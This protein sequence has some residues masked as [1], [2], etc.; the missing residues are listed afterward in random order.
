MVEQI[1]VAIPDLSGNEG[2]YLLDAFRSSWISST[3]PYVTR[4]EAEFAALTGVRHCL[5]VYLTERQRS[6][7][8]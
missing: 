2:K 8:P 3:G 5:S 4:F 1:P 7:S 6:I